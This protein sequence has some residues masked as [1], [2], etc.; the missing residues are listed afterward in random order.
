MR[1]TIIACFLLVG[2]FLSAK[3]NA[4]PNVLIILVPG[5]SW[6]DWQLYGSPEAKTPHLNRLAE[7]GARLSNFLSGPEVSSARAGLLTGRDPYRGGVGREGHGEAI[8]KSSEITI[9]EVFTSE[10]YETGFFGGW[11]NGKNWPFTAGNQ[12][13]KK[14][15]QQGIVADLTLLSRGEGPFLAVVE[16][17]N[18]NQLGFAETSPDL[19]VQAIEKVDRRVGALLDLVSWSDGDC[20][21]VLCSESGPKNADPSKPR[22]NGYLYGG[23]GSLHEGG[24][25]LPC[26][27]SWP[28]W[29]PQQHEFGRLSSIQDI[30]PTLVS[31]C[32][33]K[34]KE[35]RKLDGMDLS[36]VLTNR[37]RPDRW[38]NRILVSA[39]TADGFDWKQSGFAIRSDRWL[40][41]KD[42]KWQRDKVKAASNAGWELYD[43]QSDPFQNMDLADQYPYVLGGLRADFTRWQTLVTID[44]LQRIPIEVGH[45]EWPKVE[46]VQEEARKDGRSWH[47]KVKV[48]KE[49]DYQLQLRA[50]KEGEYSLE[51]GK[52]EHTAFHEGLGDWIDVGVLT[53][54]A[55][56]EWIRCT[57]N[58]EWRLIAK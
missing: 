47:W 22:F 51:T 19:V 43:L 11:K 8:L 10:G 35:M 55:D 45:S 15:S 53:L 29:I 27:F 16:L 44:G 28:G 40:A 30:L 58:A 36:P 57:P 9:G 2:G 33:L 12:G 46:L 18:L 32:G 24:V 6:G 37:E 41:V 38:P 49:G 3:D 42:A 13:F 20:V 14:R 52:Q 7:S 54:Q 39:R 48:V 21:V 25:R 17:E 4:S 5:M 31:L 1:T 50:G 56:L 34:P 26:V 23:N